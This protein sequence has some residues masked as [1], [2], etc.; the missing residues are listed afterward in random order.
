MVPTAHNQALV[1]A[2]MKGVGQDTPFRPVIPNAQIRRLRVLLIA[3][4]LAELAHGLGVGFTFNIGTVAPIASEEALP[5]LVESA[6]GIADL[7]YVV[8]GA[9]VAMGLDIQPIFDEVQ[10]SNMSK[11]TNGHKCEKTGKWIKGPNYS[12]AD[13]RPVV[14]AQIP[15]AGIPVLL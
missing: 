8:Y 1:H 5:A 12:P 14:A 11:V 7:L 15:E 9:A 2:F 3:E 10:R 13:L 6:D 4:E